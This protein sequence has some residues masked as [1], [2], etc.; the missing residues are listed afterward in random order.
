MTHD[1]D[2][3]IV[4][5]PH[6]G[7]R[8]LKERFAIEQHIHTIEPWEKI[9][10]AVEGKNIIAPLRSPMNVFRS[11]CRR[12]A[13]KEPFPY[14]AMVGAWYV[15]HALTLVLANIDFI[16]IDKAKDSRITDWRPVGGKDPGDWSLR[17]LTDIHALHKIPFV[18][19]H[20]GSSV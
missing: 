11:W 16:N 13:P 19:K 4:S 20:F 17:E 2:T 6:S 14:T 18:R 1:R 10:E 8:F 15:M 5:I 9:C 12:R 7:T 3:I